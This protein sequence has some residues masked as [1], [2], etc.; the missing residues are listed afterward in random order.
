MSCPA[1]TPLASSVFVRIVH[2][3]PKR[4]V[5]VSKSPL[6]SA[7]IMVCVH[8]LRGSKRG[9]VAA[10]SSVTLDLQH[11]QGPTMLGTAAS[12]G[13]CVWSVPRCSTIGE[14]RP[15]LIKW[16]VSDASSVSC[17]AAGLEVPGVPKETVQSLAQQLVRRLLKLLG[18]NLQRHVKS[19]S[20]A[21]FQR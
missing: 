4:Q 14:F 20:L 5:L 7:D 10:E 12:D 6:E 19:E 2:M 13:T 8:S 15:S 9:A 17:D 18:N 3:A 16:Q 21:S 1:N 11:H